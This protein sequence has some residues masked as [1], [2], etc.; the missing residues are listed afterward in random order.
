MNCRIVGLAVAAFAFASAGPV[1]ADT[2]SFVNSP[3]T[4][5]SD[6]AAFAAS[7][8]DAVTT[9]D[10]EAHP[11]GLL[12]P[13]FFASQGVTL[14]YTGSMQL[15]FGPGPGQANTTSPPTSTGEGLHQDSKYLLINPLPATLTVSLAQ[16]ASGIGLMTIDLFNPRQNPHNEV[17]VQAFTGPSGTG[18]SLGT[19]DAAGFNFQRDYLYFMGV[20]TT[21]ADIRSL[22]LTDPAG[23][24]DS[25]AIDKIM[26]ATAPAATPEPATI[27]LLA[28][29]LIG[30]AF[31]RRQ[32]KH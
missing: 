22:V 1:R 13:N 23:G 24:A 27:A 3:A 2:I 26:F 18:M 6:F 20:G 7:E 16:P 9:L 15:A 29:G 30:G 5:S 8:G 17:T 28:T 4:N 21:G 19:F 14:S 12:Q 25:I 32:T 11:Y 10:F 31:R